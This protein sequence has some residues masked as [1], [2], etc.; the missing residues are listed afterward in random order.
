[1]YTAPCQLVER[2]FYNLRIDLKLLLEY[3][4][5]IVRARIPSFIRTPNNAFNIKVGMAETLDFYEF[6]FTSSFNAS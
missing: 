6:K 1:M 2:K 5:C 4:H 3:Y